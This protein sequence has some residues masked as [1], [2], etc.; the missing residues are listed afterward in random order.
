MSVI[1]VKV[2]DRLDGVSN[3]LPWKASLILLLKEQELWEVVTG[4][5]P[6]PTPTQTTTPGG[7][8][9]VK[10]DPACYPHFVE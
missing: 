1:S 4:G 9:Q 10:P 2:E 3:F 8:Q 7:T 6:A 5:V